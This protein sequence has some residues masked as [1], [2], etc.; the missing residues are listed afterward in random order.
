L[1]VAAL[2]STRWSSHSPKA[3]SISAPEQ[4]QLVACS[5]EQPLVQLELGGEVA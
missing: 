3:W 5:L 2:I 1:S 4:E